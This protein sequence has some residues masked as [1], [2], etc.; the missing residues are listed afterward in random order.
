MGRAA[1][2]GLKAEGASA[3]E[4]VEHAEAGK[5]RTEAAGEYV[6]HGFADAIGRRANGFVR[7]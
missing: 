7:R 3:G 5:D 4:K 2:Q 6:E 1:R